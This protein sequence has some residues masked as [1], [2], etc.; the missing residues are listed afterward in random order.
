MYNGYS[1]IVNREYGHLNEVLEWTRE[2]IT[3]DWGWDIWSEP[4]SAHPTSYKFFFETQEDLVAF[5]LRWQKEVD[6]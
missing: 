6:N 4:A 1:V 5:A 3:N 2:N